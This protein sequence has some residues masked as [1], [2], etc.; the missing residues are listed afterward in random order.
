MALHSLG[1]LKL[2]LKISRKFACSSA[3]ELFYIPFSGIRSIY[4]LSVAVQLRWRKPRRDQGHSWRM[5]L[6]HLKHVK[7]FHTI[8]VSFPF[9][10]DILG[11]INFLHTLIISD[12]KLFP[13]QSEGN[14]RGAKLSKLTPKWGLRRINVKNMKYEI[15][16]ITNKAFGAEIRQTAAGIC[17]I[18]LIK[19]LNNK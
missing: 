11:D 8:I 18:W 4:L 19:T 16:L 14:K 15:W 7:L 13:L 6:E 2:S 12:H 1:I 10:E 5:L 9:Y 17:L 3:L